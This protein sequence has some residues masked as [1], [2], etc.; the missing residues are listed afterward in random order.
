MTSNNTEKETLVFT[1]FIAGQKRNSTLARRN[2]AQICQTHFAAHHKII[3]VDILQDFQAALDNGILVSPALRVALPDSEI[4]LVG[5][6]SDTQ[7]VLAALG[8]VVKE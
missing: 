6:L 7:N 1:L 3:I 5:D 4:T 2:L 8:A